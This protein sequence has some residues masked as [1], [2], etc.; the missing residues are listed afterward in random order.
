MASEQ[1]VVPTTIIQSPSNLSSLNTKEFY[2]K[3]SFFKN[4]IG[5]SNTSTHAEAKENGVTRPSNIGSFVLL[6]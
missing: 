6:I 5:V 1:G 4:E 2:L 3:E